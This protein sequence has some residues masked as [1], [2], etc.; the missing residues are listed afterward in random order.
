MKPSTL[1][2]KNKTIPRIETISQPPIQEPNDTHNERNEIRNTQ[3]S[4]FERAESEHEL[5]E[6]QEEIDFTSKEPPTYEGDLEEY[7]EKVLL[8]AVEDRL[9]SEQSLPIET[10]MNDIKTMILVQE[11]EDKVISQEDWNKLR[12]IIEEHDENVEELIPK[13]VDQETVDDYKQQVHDLVDTK[14]SE[15]HAKRKLTASKIDKIDK[16]RTETLE[17]IDD[18]KEDVEKFHETTDKEERQELVKQIE[19]NNPEKLLNDV[20]TILDT[21]AFEEPQEEQ[22]LQF[23]IEENEHEQSEGEQQETNTV[24][25]IEPILQGENKPTKQVPKHRLEISDVQTEAFNVDRIEPILQGENKPTKQAPKP[26]LEISD[27]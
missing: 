25:R 12:E 13:E 18:W 17:R 16:L 23:N 14:T 5:R 20:E 1:P 27:N 3:T 15:S 6:L 10:T 8:P 11:D 22:P 24:D 26:R 21:I 9:Y 7:R 19:E 2:Y 4:G